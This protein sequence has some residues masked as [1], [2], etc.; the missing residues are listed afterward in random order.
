MHYLSEAYVVDEIPLYSAKTK[1]ELSYKAKIYDEDVSFN[2][3]RVNDGRYDLDHNLENIVFNELLY[4][5]YDLR[6]F[7]NKG[8]EIDFLASKNGKKYFVQVAYS[9]LSEKAYEREFAAFNDL[10][11]ANQKIL[12][13][14]DEL[15]YSTSTV[16]HIK[17]KDFLL[18]D[19]F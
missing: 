13:T 16:R 3:L 15:D 12:I 11:N 1:R 14:N 2:S 7:D 8:K 10:D 5:G 18:M 17:F 6:V 19:D 4:R 9:V